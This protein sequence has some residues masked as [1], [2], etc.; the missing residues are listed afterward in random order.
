M[1]WAGCIIGAYLVGSIPFGLILGRMRGVDI[2]EHGS[3]NIGATNVGRVLGRKLGSL[4]FVLDLLKGAG[5]VLVAGFACEVLGR[6]PAPGG[7]TTNEMWLWMLVAVAAVI[8]HMASIF[9][10]FRGGKGVATSF[11]AMLALWPVLTLPALAALVVW[12]AVVRFT[13]I[14][15]LASLCA[16]VSLPVWYVVSVI[17]NTGD[18]LAQLRH[19]SPPLVVTILLAALVVWRHRANIGRLMRG[20]ESKL[21]S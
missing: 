15:S 8:G 14:V 2:R 3:K 20:E 10:Y 9:L 5:P 18:T 13:R 19:A 4:C 11:G 7:L 1:I 12:Y 16:A 21:K 6:R 17:P